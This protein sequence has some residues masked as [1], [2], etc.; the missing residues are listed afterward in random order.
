MRMTS[1]KVEFG[2]LLFYNFFK[3]ILKIFISAAAV[4]KSGRFIMI[5]WRSCLLLFYFFVHISGFYQSRKYTQNDTPLILL[6]LLIDN[7]A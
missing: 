6:L 3:V 7:N 1:L 4:A 5:S 2:N